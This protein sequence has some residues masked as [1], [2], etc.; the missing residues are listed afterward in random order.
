MNRFVLAALLVISFGLAHAE[1][2]KG[3]EG[4]YCGSKAS[5]LSQDD[6]SFRL[7][8][9]FEYTARDSVSKNFV[10]ASDVIYKG[11]S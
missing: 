6:T 10:E 3:E 9:V 1:S 7:G 8:K 4:W 11:Q 5:Y 2:L